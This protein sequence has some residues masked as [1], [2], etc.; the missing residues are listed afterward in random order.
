MKSYIDNRY[1]SLSS[2]T[3]IIF[4]IFCSIVTGA[5]VV[6]SSYI[7]ILILFLIPIV[8]WSYKEPLRAVSLMV[9]IVPFAETEFL[10]ERVVDIPGA[11]PLI[12]IAVYA[13]IVFILSENKKVPMPKNSRVFVLIFIGI[14]TLSI[15]RSLP[16]LH[17]IQKFSVLELSLSGYLLSHYLKPL[18]FF[19]PFI[20]VIKCIKGQKDIDLLTDAI[21]ISLSLISLCLIYLFFM[22][23]NFYTEFRG[24]STIYA[25]FF[26][27]HRNQIAS[28]FIVGFPLL[29]YKY[30]ISKSWLSIVLLLLN[31]FAIAIL[32]SR[33]GY[34]ALFLFIAAYLFIIKNNKLISLAI[35]IFVVSMFSFNSIVS[36][37]LLTGLDSNGINANEVSSGRI[38]NIW[39]PLVLE[40]ID[41]PEKLIFGEGRYAIASSD[42]MKRNIILNVFNVHNMYLELIFDIGLIGF[43]LIVPRIFSF[44]W[45]LFKNKTSSLFNHQAELRGM[46]LISIMTFLL[47]G[48]SGSCFFPRLSNF[49]F[50]IVLGM[51]V[52]VANLTTS[53]S[54]K[55]EL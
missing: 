37:R 44:F 23:S 27:M 45:T 36:D 13:L 16:N 50:W 34:A 51:T 14:F 40:F 39:K 12:I 7:S 25:E 11:K 49:L 4:T 2:A 54:L 5:I 35:I 46:L 52:S 41:S 21:S 31:I 8:Y 48:M 28:Y 47:A 43:F 33:T 26:G 55:E 9:L 1:D 3:M 30:H 19:M 24:I 6:Y 17:E 15:F 22:K 32:F 10:R 53:V 29:V 42:A 20:L 38:D 18:V